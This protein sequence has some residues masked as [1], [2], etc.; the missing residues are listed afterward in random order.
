MFEKRM[1]GYRAIGYVRGPAHV[2]REEMDDD[3][4]ESVD[5]AATAE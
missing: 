5:A 3:P 2:G 4:R 1:R